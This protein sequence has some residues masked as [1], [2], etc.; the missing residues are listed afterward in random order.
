MVEGLSFLLAILLWIGRLPLSLLFSALRGLLEVGTWPS[1][2]MKVQQLPLSDSDLIEG[3][4]VHSF[5]QNPVTARP[6]G[7]AC[8]RAPVSEGCI[9]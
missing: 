3:V 7:Q 9:S 4:R 6:P 8:S 2:K 1:V 5:A